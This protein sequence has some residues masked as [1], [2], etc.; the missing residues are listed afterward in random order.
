MAVV[1]ANSEACTTLQLTS[2]ASSPLHFHDGA[3]NTSVSQKR[4]PRL[5]HLLMNDT[6]MERSES[7]IG[8]N[9]PVS[10]V[11]IKA[12]PQL[13]QIND[14]Y[15]DALFAMSY[16]SPLPTA[17]PESPPQPGTPLKDARITINNLLKDISAHEITCGRKVT[18]RPTRVLLKSLEEEVDSYQSQTRLK[19]RLPSSLSSQEKSVQQRRSGKR[20]REK[21]SDNHDEEKKKKADKVKTPFI[22]G[23]TEGDKS[24]LID[25]EI[26]VD[27]SS[28]RKS[29]VLEEETKINDLKIRSYD[30]KERAEKREESDNCFETRGQPMEITHVCLEKENQ[31]V[32]AETEIIQQEILIKEMITSDQD[33]QSEENFVFSVEEITEDKNESKKFSIED[34]AS[35]HVIEFPPNSSLVSREIADLQLS[36]DGI[37]SERGSLSESIPSWLGS[38]HSL[39]Q[40]PSRSSSTLHFLRSDSSSSVWN[41]ENNS[42][43]EDHISTE[44]K[45]LV[46]PQSLI[47][48]PQVFRSSTVYANLVDGPTRQHVISTMELYNIS[49]ADNGAPFWGDP[50]DL[51]SGTKSKDYGRIT[52][53]IGSNLV[54]NLP[55]FGSIQQQ[56]KPRIGLSLL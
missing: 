22:R 37:T 54:R 43:P 42:L 2:P 15:T 28:G 13:K 9:R 3:G 35:V 10:A 24:A 39:S 36:N 6:Q 51:L 12:K 47:V 27:C 53:P 11:D 20:Q 21:K 29:L 26:C 4:M 49:P 5:S 23:E 16:L 55:D 19:L 18:I 7:D 40:N 8:P 30:S 1:K 52:V 32:V 31:V 17:A 38:S 41:D 34:K 56:V 14:E 33:R 25:E 44:E 50:K 46:D 45:P 48:P